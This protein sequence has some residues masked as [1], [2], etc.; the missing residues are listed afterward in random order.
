VAAYELLSNLPNLDI[1]TAQAPPIAPMA[2][3]RQHTTLPFCLYPPSIFLLPLHSNIPIIFE[4]CSLNL[5]RVACSRSF[6]NLLSG[7]DVGFSSNVH[8]RRL[9]FQSYRTSSKP[10]E[11]SEE[12]PRDFA[13]TPYVPRQL[14]ARLCCIQGQTNLLIRLIT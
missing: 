2:K 9:H 13:Y 6:C 10:I 12:R 5:L 11:D 14:E 3:P 8:A 4:S 1:I 7:S